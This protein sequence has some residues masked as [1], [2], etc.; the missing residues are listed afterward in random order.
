V[1]CRFERRGVRDSGG[2]ST[3]AAALLAAAM[4]LAAAEPGIA[5]PLARDA[6]PADYSVRLDALWNFEQP[7]ESEVRLRT[8]ASRHA[9]GSREAAEA[10]TQIARALGLQRRFAETDHTLDTVKRTLARQPARVRVRYLLERG[11]RDNSSGSKSKAIAWFEQALTAS[12]DD[13]L[14]GADFYRVDALHMLAIAAPPARQLAL[15]LRAL[16]TADA[17]QDARTRSWRASLL[18]NLGWTMHERGDYAAALVYWQDARAAFEAKHDLV[19]TRIARWTV[20]RGMRS[21]GRLDEAEAI[22]HHLADELQAANAPD[23]YVF[24]ELA[25]IALA[26]GDRAAAQPW[27]AKA[28][29]LLSRD[30]NLRARE[31]ARLA[32]LADLAR[33]SPPNAVTR[34]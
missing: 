30:A 21:L 16:A 10:A 22:Q 19:G 11:R 20:A 25:E 15:N 4:L 9:P 34:Q 1:R 5:M 31:P 8:E 33:T 12:A 13:T 26:R 7:A 18:N 28:L 29:A 14:P 17:A 2:A 3:L 27:A 24:E 32:R 23:G 6:L